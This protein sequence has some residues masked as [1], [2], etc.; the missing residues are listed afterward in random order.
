MA[1]VRWLGLR[2]SPQQIAREKRIDAPVSGAVPQR[3]RLSRLAHCLGGL[4]EQGWRPEQG[5]RRPVNIRLGRLVYRNPP[6]EVKGQLQKKPY[7]GV[8]AERSRNAAKT[9]HG[10]REVETLR[11]DDPNTTRQA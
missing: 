10:F 1:G 2:F 9:A 3:P 5:W 8:A 4:L 11:L 7:A 6:T